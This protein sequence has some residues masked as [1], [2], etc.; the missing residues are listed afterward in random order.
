MTRK[1]RFFTLLGVLALT[2]NP[3]NSQIRWQEAESYTHASVEAHLA[4]S[5]KA[6]ASGGASVAGVAFGEAGQQVAYRM[7]LEAPV[8]RAVLWLRYARLHFREGMDPAR[9]AVAVQAGSAQLEAA[10]TCGNTG[11]WGSLRGKEWHWLRVPLGADLPAG[12]L[13]LAFRAEEAGAN[14]N[15][16]GFYLASEAFAMEPETGRSFE[17]VR[18]FNDGYAGLRIPGDTVFPGAFDGFA[19]VLREF[20]GGSRPVAIELLEASGTATPLLNPARVSL[21][22]EPLAIE[23][24]AA[25]LDPFP[26]GDYTLRLSCRESEPPLTY[27]LTILRDGVQAAREAAAAFHE[28]ALRFKEDGSLAEVA[29]VPDL[30]HAADYLENAIL[31]LEARQRGEATTSQR[32]AALAYFEKSPARTA[33]QFA[34]DMAGLIAQTRES[35][36]RAAGGRAAF[37]ERTGEFRRAFYSGVTGTLE[38]YRVFVPE[39]YSGLESIPL[40]LMLH[41]GGGDENYFPDL[42]DGAVLA[43]L[44]DRPCILLS[45]RSTHWFEGAGVADMRQLVGIALEAYP[46][47]DTSRIYCTGVSRGGWGTFNLALHY[48]DLFAAVA[49]VSSAPEIT[50]AARR[51]AQTPVLLINGERDGVVP[52][53]G[54]RRAARELEELGIPHRLVTFPDYGHEYHPVEYLN[55][56]LDFF[57]NPQS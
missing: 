20:H 53:Q 12:P 24:E 7:E 48:P 55:L 15:L 47:I 39:A 26:D 30:L 52:V 23:V 9:L 40:L 33:R 28:R 17:R 45:P 34:R 13:E 1:P 38:P 37:A 27:P 54:A 25:A 5:E 16:D 50:S 36:E 31:L 35:L 8:P 46:K 49:C 14:I 32:V 2:M 51:L 3:L 44:E 10:F 18:F 22:S 11:G 42:G 41:G 4:V 6:P 19:L 21:R 29:L 56:T 43:V 57:E